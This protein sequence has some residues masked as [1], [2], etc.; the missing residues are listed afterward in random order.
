LVALLLRAASL[1]FCTRRR[2]SRRAA[3]PTQHH[4]PRADARLPR[5]FRSFPPRAVIL[6][7]FL[8]PGAVLANQT[9]Y[10]PDNPEWNGCSELA[11][12]ARG[13]Q[14]Q[15]ELLEELDW[16]RIP[17]GSTLLFLYPTAPIDTQALMLFMK[18]GGKVLLADD[19]GRFD[20]VFE[21]LNIRR[22]AGRPVSTSRY[23][24]ENGNL[25]IA[26]AG[27][28]AHALGEGVSVV[29]A[30]HPA[31]FRSEYPTLVGF[32]GGQQLVVAGKLGQGRFVAL[33][34]PSVLINAMVRFEGNQALAVNIL[35]YLRPPQP[36]DRI[37]VVTGHFRSL[38][39]P[40]E[41][42]AHRDSVQKFLTD[43]SRFLG[44]V[45]DFAPTQPAL[46]ALAVV[47]GL[48]GL[49]GLVLL[50]PLP[51]REL[52]GHWLRPV[53]LQRGDIPADKLAFLGNHEGHAKAAFSAAILREEIEEV[54]TE[55]LDAPG[56]VFTIHPKWVVHRVR[57]VVG[58]DAARV[59]SRLL[60]AMKNVS[61]TASVG[62]IAAFQGVRQSDLASMYE[63]SRRLLILLG[64][65]PLPEVSSRGDSTWPR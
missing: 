56:P 54:L 3:Q 25:P 61:Q 55:V 44:R 37:Y 58:D 47:A 62:G 18:D 12:L 1:L 59:C 38:G 29:V 40:G 22:V 64:R 48:V 19:F 8:A 31:F 53:G 14:L 30:N 21:S 15:I 43:Y 32:G 34:D 26:R 27:P 2:R 20:V 46:R 57:E 9:D 11:A 17:R 13:L 49:V 41:R 51:R 6:A 36:A 4:Q 24:N 65:H 23:H 45:N 42:A 7:V 33:S 10:L 60:A 28:A 35:H 50:L 52:S 39:R 16:G 5:A 63:L